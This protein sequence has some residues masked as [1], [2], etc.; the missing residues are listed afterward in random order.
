MIMYTWRR[1]T[2]LLAL[3]TRRVEV[4]FEPL[5]KSLEAKPPHVVPGTAVFLTSD[6]DFAPTALLHNLKHNKVLHEHNVI[7]TIVNED[8]PHVAL[9]DR[10]QIEPISGKFMRLVLHFGFME[11]A[12]RAEG[13][14]G[15]AQAR[16]AIRHHVDVVLPVAPVGETGPALRH[17]E[18]A[19]RALHLPRA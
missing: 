5:V 10:V 9:K 1:G 11:T 17:A 15:R 12:E 18:M 19:G 4:P 14:G 13:L 3:K 7:L 2:R 8:I 6:P 16:L